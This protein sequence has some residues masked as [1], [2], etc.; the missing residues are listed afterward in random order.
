MTHKTSDA[1]AMSRLLFE[2]YEDDV[3]AVAIAIFVRAVIDVKK[4]RNDA[5]KRVHETNDEKNPYW[6][7]KKQ[8]QN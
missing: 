8:Y 7:L 3:V 6:Y 5:I 2:E 1:Y 4:L